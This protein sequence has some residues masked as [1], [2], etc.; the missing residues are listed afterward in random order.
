MHQPVKRWLVGRDTEL[1]QLQVGH[2]QSK[3]REWS[4]F[5]FP[6]EGY[7]LEHSIAR[8]Y[9]EALDRSSAYLVYKLV[10]S[11]NFSIGRMF[12]TQ[13]GGRSWQERSIPIGEEVHFLNPNDG[14]TAGGATGKEF[15][16]TNDGGMTWQP[17][18]SNGFIQDQNSVI[19]DHLN[20]PNGARNTSAI[21]RFQAWTLLE[22]SNCEGDKAAGQIACQES[23][24]LLSTNDGGITWSQIYLR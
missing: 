2:S 19:A 10:S 18:L 22:D 24:T 13:D 11:S 9:I 7:D 12:F 14:W 16:Q 6:E 17:L 3:S 23:A 5:P 1:G 8:I 4:F 20:L 21:N 15:Y